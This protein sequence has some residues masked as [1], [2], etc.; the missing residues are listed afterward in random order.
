LSPEL[1][2]TSAELAPLILVADDEPDLFALTVMQLAK[3][4][5]RTVSASDGDQVVALAESA[6]PDAVLLDVEMPGL[7]GTE[8]A[9]RRRQLPA[10]RAIPVILM[11]ARTSPADEATALAAGALA[12]LAKP[13][14]WNDLTRRLTEVTLGAP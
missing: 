14:D 7:S 8:V 5:Y 13:L 12:Q 4:G 2:P 6:K 11:S 1:A 10:T 3:A 9:E